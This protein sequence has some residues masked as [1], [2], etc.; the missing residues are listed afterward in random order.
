MLNPTTL[1]LYLYA[2]GTPP[3]RPPQ[4][5]Y[6]AQYSLKPGIDEMILPHT[7]QTASIVPAF[8]P[9]WNTTVWATVITDTYLK[10]RF[11]VQTPLKAAT[12]DY[13]VNRGTG[14][15]VTS[16]VTTWTVSHNFND[17][18]AVILFAS[19]WNTTIRVRTK[20]ANSTIVDFSTPAPTGA[21]LYYGL[22]QDDSDITSTEVVSDAAKTHTIR[23]NA[24]R[25]FLPIFVQPS[26]YTTVTWKEKLDLNQTVIS[27]GTPP[28]GA[29]T[30]DTRV[31][32]IG[33]MVVS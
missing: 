30:M 33:N 26:W 17:A 2:G 3:S 32:A 16:G 31:K 13:S 11:G 29:A 24:S 22:H 8:T 18:T 14:V 15:A 7:L 4:T 28:S 27:F 10:V 21:Y 5:F 20:A 19:N 9:S 1:Y 6:Q 23:H 12:L 25:A